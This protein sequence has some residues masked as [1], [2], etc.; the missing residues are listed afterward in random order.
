MLY[1]S[2]QAR[3]TAKDNVHYYL[4]KLGSVKPT[5][6]L[7]LQDIR[8]IRYYLEVLSDG[9]DREIRSEKRKELETARLH[10]EKAGA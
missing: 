6:D 2:M 3:E 10:E 1:T 4:V 5:E 8:N 7:T 9:L